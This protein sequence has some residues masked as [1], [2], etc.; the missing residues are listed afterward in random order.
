M[1]TRISIW[2]FLVQQILVFAYFGAAIV[3]IYSKY[4]SCWKHENIMV[5]NAAWKNIHK[6]RVCLSLS[7]LVFSFPE[8]CNKNLWRQDRN[9]SMYGN[10]RDVVLILVPVVIL[11]V[12][13][14][15]CIL[16]LKL[17][18]A[19]EVNCLQTFGIQISAWMIF[20]HN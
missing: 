10:R 1:C 3:Q 7:R 6:T 14:S 5:I 4:I 12:C 17:C 9:C 20:P 2:N 18:S 16:L 19:S 13:T 8:Q 15:N 11:E